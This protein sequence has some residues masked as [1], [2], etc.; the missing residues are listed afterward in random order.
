ME[1]LT[2]SSFAEKKRL[3][4]LG[5]VSKAA[6]GLAAVLPFASRAD[7]QIFTPAQPIVV[8]V[9]NHVW[10]DPW[11][12]SGQVQ[13]DNPGFLLHFYFGSGAHLQFYPVTSG[14]YSVQWALDGTNVFQA[15]ATLDAA[16]SWNA[17]WAF[18]QQQTHGYLAYRVFD[19]T[20]NDY[21]YGWI[22]FEHNS[23]AFT[24]TVTRWALNTTDGEITVGVIPEP[25]VTGLL[26]GA[27]FIGVAFYARWRKRVRG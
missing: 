5:A 24:F 19:S 9:W 21:D 3:L 1:H 4:G 8:P 27:L 16:D 17:Q 26:A 11:S 22:E 12:N 7:T 6:G 20:T 2:A 15:G 14:D 10:L 25:A 23:N 18:L 13:T